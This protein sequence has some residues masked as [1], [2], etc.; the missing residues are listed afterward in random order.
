MREIGKHHGSEAVLQVRGS[1]EFYEQF[2]RQ[3]A[4]LSWPDVET[5]ARKF[6]PFLQSSFPAY[7]E[8]M[9]G[10]ADGA[11]VSF[12][13]VL[14]LNVRTEIAYGLAADGCTAFA[15]KTENDSFIG[16]NWDVCVTFPDLLASNRT[17]T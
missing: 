14:A 5:E 16:Q 13:S 17:N 9:Q 10:V 6:K 2:F 8:E 3:T 4:R 12:D 15:W 1:I 7:I 11:G